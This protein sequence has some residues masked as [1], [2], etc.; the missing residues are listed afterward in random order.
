MSIGVA[1]R[2]SDIPKFL[3]SE[4]TWTQRLGDGWKGVKFLGKGSFGVVGLWR[5]EGEEGP[6]APEVREVVVKQSNLYLNHNVEPLFGMTG[7][8]E[9]QMLEKLSKTGSQH[10]IRQYGG[11]H[12]GDRFGDM[13]QVV[14]LFLEYCPGGDVDQLLAGVDRNGNQLPRKPPIGEADLWALFTCMALG[15][16]VMHRGTEVTSEPA[17]GGQYLLQRVETEICHFD[18][19]PDNRESILF[20]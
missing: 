11:F 17:W 2:D 8:D 1:F 16:V 5:Y 9:G 6:N 4:P 19:K 14:K 7:L 13:D 18:I 20:F 3:A 15:V 10:I 12:T